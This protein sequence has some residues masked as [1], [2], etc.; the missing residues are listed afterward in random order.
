MNELKHLI[1]MEQGPTLFLFQ[2]HHIL[3]EKDTVSPPPSPGDNQHPALN[4]GLP[5]YTAELMV[6]NFYEHSKTVSHS[7]PHQGGQHSRKKVRISPWRGMQIDQKSSCSYPKE[8]EESGQGTTA[9]P[10]LKP[11]AQPRHS[12]GGRL[13]LPFPGIR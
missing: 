9:C 4:K 7:F 3:Q 1:K 13:Q 2:S 11:Q 10:H 6:V 5:K 8:S 12:I